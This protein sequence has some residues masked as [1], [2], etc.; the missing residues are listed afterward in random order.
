M[1]VNL[2]DPEILALLQNKAIE[3]HYT[4]DC[5]PAKLADP[6]T[7]KANRC[8]YELIDTTIYEIEA[9]MVAFRTTHARILPWVK[10]LHL[11]YY[12]LMGISRQI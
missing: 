6:T 10:A 8:K 3:E 7:E 1:F 5:M 11:Y 4:P 12:E 9:R 2:N